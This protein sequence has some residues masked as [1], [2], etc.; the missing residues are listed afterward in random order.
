MRRCARHDRSSLA[1]GW[2]V[3]LLKVR[4]WR[5]PNAQ[6]FRYAQHDFGVSGRNWGLSQEKQM[7]IPR[8]LRPLVMTTE[9]TLVITT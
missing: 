2:A 5:S 1:L 9:N 6:M 8:G 3:P 7:Q 4:Q